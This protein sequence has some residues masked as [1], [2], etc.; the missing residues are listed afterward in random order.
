MVH[1]FLGSLVVMDLEDQSPSYL[2]IRCYNSHR[3]SWSGHGTCMGSSHP[4]G[5]LWDMSWRRSLQCIVDVL[6]DSHLVCSILDLQW[7][8][9]FIDTSASWYR[10]GSSLRSDLDVMETGCWPW[11][12]LLPPLISC[13]ASMLDSSVASLG[14]R[15]THAPSS[16]MMASS[17]WHVVLQ[18]S[19]GTSRLMSSPRQ[20]KVHPSSSDV[21]VRSLPYFM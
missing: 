1:C 18:S 21:L 19:H 12:H 14:S 20:E 10:V 4:D 8:W 16:S 11:D 15:H 7:P 13:T 3:L 2:V 6:Q 5:R 17:S 9:S